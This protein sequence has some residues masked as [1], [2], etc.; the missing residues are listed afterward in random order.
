[1]PLITKFYF[2]FQLS[3]YSWVL[4][5]ERYPDALTVS[6]ANQ[7]IEENGLQDKYAITKHENCPVD[8]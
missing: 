4:T 5:R 3:E 2:G 7:V 1:V 6:Y 8:P